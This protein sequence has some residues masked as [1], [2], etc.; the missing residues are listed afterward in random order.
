MLSVSRLYIVDDRMITVFARWKAGILGSNPT[1]V[2]D[3]C[4]CVVLRVGSGL[5]TGW[6]LVQAVKSNV[7]RLGNWKRA[8]K[9]HKGCRAIEEEEEDRM[10]NV[11]VAAGGM[12][13]DRGKRITRRKP[14]RAAF[15]PK[16]SC[17]FH[18]NTL[19]FFLFICILKYQV[20]QS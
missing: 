11:Y 18:K 19:N 1:R 5:A 4:V 15:C 16:F 12:K 13:N 3:V 20:P 17:H 14:A 8:A 6:S 2:M 7:N 9:A 10:I